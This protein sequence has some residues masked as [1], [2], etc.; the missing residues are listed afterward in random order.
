MENCAQAFDQPL[1]SADHQTLRTTAWMGGELISVRYWLGRLLQKN[2]LRQSNDAVRDVLREYLAAN[3]CEKGSRLVSDYQAWGSLAILL[4]HQVESD[5]GCQLTK[6]PRLIAAINAVLSDPEL[7]TA[8][9]AEIAGTTEKQ[10]ARM[11]Y[12]FVL[13]KL[14]KLVRPKRWSRSILAWEFGGWRLKS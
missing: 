4:Q 1:D 12:V 10:I 8:Q 5:E 9:L 2:L 11:T 7:T 13:Q 14:W 3:G 6:N